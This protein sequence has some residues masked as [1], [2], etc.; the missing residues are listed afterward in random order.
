MRL[1]I[2]VKVTEKHV[3]I[4]GGEGE[5]LTISDIVPL[6]CRPGVINWLA[7]VSARDPSRHVLHQFFF[8][9]PDFTAAFQIYS[10]FLC[11]EHRL[12][13]KSCGSVLHP[14]R[15][16][17]VI[18]LSPNVQTAEMDYIEDDEYRNSAKVSLGRDP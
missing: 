2:F 3:L 16:P 8:L 7:P 15:F 5:V 9:I 6:I 14:Y 12:N 18:I 1:Q 10:I 4:V 13:S 17:P 11:I